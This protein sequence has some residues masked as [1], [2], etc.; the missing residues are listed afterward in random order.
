MRLDLQ[1]K[2]STILKRGKNSVNITC[3]LFW[4]ILVGN[5]TVTQWVLF[6][7]IRVHFFN[8]QKICRI[9]KQTLFENAR[10]I[11]TTYSSYFQLCRT[12]NPML[13]FL[14]KSVLCVCFFFYSH[15][16]I[17]CKTW[18]VGFECQF[19]GALR[20]APRYTR[21]EKVNAGLTL[22]LHV[23]GSVPLNTYQEYLL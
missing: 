22:K 15:F 17:V 13:I 4:Q 18:T 5:K 6:L 8:T 16:Y 1:R 3:G 7:M 14:Q 19:E 21:F 12:R 9:G 10:K 20:F 11:L 2:I 23:F